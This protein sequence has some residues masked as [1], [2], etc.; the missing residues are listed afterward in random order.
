MRFSLIVL[1][2]TKNHESNLKIHKLKISD[3]IETPTFRDIN[4]IIGQIK[5]VS[6]FNQD[7]LYLMNQ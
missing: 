3:F 2:M 6:K 5:D 1:L 7:I 4:K